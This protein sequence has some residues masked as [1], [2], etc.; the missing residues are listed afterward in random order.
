MGKETHWTRFQ[1]EIADGKL[2]HQT[3]LNALAE[4]VEALAR[5]QR[6]AAHEAEDGESAAI[7]RAT[8]EALDSVAS[9]LQVHA[10]VHIGDEPTLI[11]KD[12]AARLV[13]AEPKGAKR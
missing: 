8:A 7:F 13:S 6:D 3:S 2:R 11:D 9:T 5:T 12:K 10:L 1:Q 4:Q